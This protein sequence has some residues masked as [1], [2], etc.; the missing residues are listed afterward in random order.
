M[1]LVTGVSGFIGRHL[2]AAIVTEY[3]SDH[4]V[5][6]TS[7]PISECSY[8]LHHNY[9]FS[10]NYFIKSGYSAIHTLIH[11]G[12]FTP[13]NKSEANDWVKCNGNIFSTNKLFLSHLPA[14]QKIIYLSTL[15]VYAPHTIITENSALGPASLY[16][17]SKLYCERMIESWASTNDK[18]CQILRVGHVYGPGEEAYEKIIP[19]TIK[20][21]LKRES[22]KIWGSGDDIRSF[23]YIDDIIKA[24]LKCLQLKK[25]PGIINLVSSEK[26]SIKA[27]VEKLL[28][29][30]GLRNIVIEFLPS[31]SGNRDLIFDNTKM[32]QYLL[33]FEKPLD[34]GLSLEWRYAK[35]RNL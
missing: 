25:N 13:K 8:L 6:L 2:L 19:M 5:A 15:D 21:L 20:K 23:I 33:D 34:E 26:I 22:I 1:I 18:L 35:E 31:D 7:K 27:L 28:E 14:L 32:R 16:G 29:I 17:S 11:V 12:A 24:I 9:T 4:V 10:K 3:G 30:S